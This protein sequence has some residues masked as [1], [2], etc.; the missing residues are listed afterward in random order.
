M[1]KCVC[2]FDRRGLVSMEDAAL[3]RT[4]HFK[5]DRFRARNQSAADRQCWIRAVAVKAEPSRLTYTFRTEAFEINVVYELRAGWRFASKQ[6]LVSGVHA[7]SFHVGAAEPLQFEIEDLLVRTLRAEQPVPEAHPLRAA[8]YL[9]PFTRRTRELGTP[10]PN[11]TLPSCAWR[12]REGFSMLLQIL[13]SSA[14]ARAKSFR[15]AT[16]RRWIRKTAWGPFPCDRACLGPY[17][18]SG[19]KIPKDPRRSG[20]SRQAL[21]TARTRRRWMRSPNACAPS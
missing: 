1:N 7:G 3:G 5:T 15:C 20:S 9:P 11:L 8:G 21:P 12:R 17:R 10:A 16:R 18:L 13:S 6:V 2:M 19:R 14:S 4:F